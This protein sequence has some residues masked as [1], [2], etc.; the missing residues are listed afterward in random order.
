MIALSF[1][2]LGA[3]FLPLPAS[4]TTTSCGTLCSGTDGSSGLNIANKY[5]QVYM[6]EVGTATYDWGGKVG[7][8][9]AWWDGMC[10]NTA[11]ANYAMTRRAHNGGL[12]VTF[13]YKS[14]G[15]ASPSVPTG[16]TAYCW[17]WDQ[18]QAAVSHI[19]NHFTTYM[20]N[21][22][23]TEIALDIEGVNATG[24]NAGNYLNNRLT[25]N[26]FTDYLA[27]RTKNTSSCSG[28][29]TTWDFQYM[30]Y[31][32][33]YTWHTLVGTYTDIPSTPVMTDEPVCTSFSE[34]SNL[35]RG[36]HWYYG[37]SKDWVSYSNYFTNW[38]FW[39]TRCTGGSH[40]YD[41]DVGTHSWYMPV[42]GRYMT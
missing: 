22:T 10:F 15:P 25:F 12:G 39:V 31:A 30:I 34:P 27:G 35:T 19:Y 2:L 5:P 16:V 32:N 7:P 20:S 37:G 40:P 14:D 13:Y 9:P 28:H 26:G 38:Q 23:Y 21:M 18:G 33:P 24:W 3:A 29:N 11:G 6:G 8:C 1:I 36:E 42:F 4:A 17:G 41:Y